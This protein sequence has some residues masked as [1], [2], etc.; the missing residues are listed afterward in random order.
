M[1]AVDDAAAEVAFGAL[2]KLLRVVAQSL[3][4]LFVERVVDIGVEEEELQA[5]ADGI[6]VENGLP[7]FAEDV[8]AHVA[9]EVDVGVVHGRCALHLR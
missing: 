1:T 6:E 2:R 9:V 8:E 7:V 5:V 4:R 3:S